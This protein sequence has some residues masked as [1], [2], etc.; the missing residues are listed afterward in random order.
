MSSKIQGIMAQWGSPHPISLRHRLS[1]PLVE[2]LFSEI[3]A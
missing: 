3:V 1:I 2:G